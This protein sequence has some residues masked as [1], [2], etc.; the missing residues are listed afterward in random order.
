MR[1]RRLRG[2]GC[3]GI[4]VVY[5]RTNLVVIIAS[6]AE[7]LDPVTD[8]LVA[9]KTLR[10]IRKYQHCRKETTYALDNESTLFWVVRP[11]VDIE[12][13]HRRVTLGATRDEKLFECQ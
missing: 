1:L 5:R 11:F 13:T 8:G 7:V 9:V 3:A 4:V 10:T 6:D 12:R 2:N